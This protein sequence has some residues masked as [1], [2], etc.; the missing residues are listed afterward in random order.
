MRRTTRKLDL[1]L[2][3]T[4]V[5]AARGEPARAARDTDVAGFLHG[6]AGV[7]FAGTAER[8]RMFEYAVQVGKLRQGE[9]GPRF[10]LRFGFVPGAELFGEIPIVSSGYRSY[11]DVAA[12]TPCSYGAG[13]D[14]LQSGPNCN[15]G[16]SIH[17][18]PDGNRY[19]ANP[20]V[21]ST[22]S[23]S[24]SGTDDIIV[25]VRFAP[26]HETDLGS[27]ETLRQ[28]AHPSFPPL[29]TWRMEVGAIVNTG[30]NFYQ[31]GPG[32][33]ATGLLLGT[34]FSKNLGISDPYISIR[35][36]RYGDF[37][38]SY[39]D[40]TGQ[41]NTYLLTP[42]DETTAL[43]GVELLPFV[44][45]GSGAKFVVD[46]AFGGHYWSRSTVISGTLLPSVITESYLYG[47]EE[48]APTSG[49]VV[50]EESRLGYEFR[51]RLQYQIFRYLRIDALGD[52]RYVLPHR[53]E[54]PYRILQG[55]TVQARYSVSLTSTF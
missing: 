27:F 10:Q 11:A 53:L 39:T 1:I 23:F 28:P 51:L 50:S 35:T 29:A 44:D 16:S 33:G 4:L 13:D 25:G 45:P 19:V 41:T 24:W 32:A 12:V 22:P 48:V 15:V 18:D 26:F 3:A 20:Q 8:S 21:A 9:A 49:S 47:S 6:E 38:T 30:S 52:L 7:G 17:L 36:L 46:F 31:G 34:S 42:P 55:H 54:S 43:F 2:F 14:V 37:E 40:A 5:L